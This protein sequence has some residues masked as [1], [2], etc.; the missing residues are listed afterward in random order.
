MKKGFLYGIIVGVILS[1]LIIFT[2]ILGSDYRY[3]YQIIYVPILLIISGLI[4][5]LIGK[6]YTYEK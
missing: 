2:P 4:G 6:F 3:G 1:I 5:L